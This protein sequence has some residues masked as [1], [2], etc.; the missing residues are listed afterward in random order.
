MI[1]WSVEDTSAEVGCAESSSAWFSTI[2]GWNAATSGI[3]RKRA[4]LLASF[5]H[6][7]MIPTIS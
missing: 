1:F 5:A 7:A 2:F 6:G 3:E 4:F